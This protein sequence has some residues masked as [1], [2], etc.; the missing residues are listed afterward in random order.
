MLANYGVEGETYTLENGEPRF[1][2]MILNNDTYSYV[3][4]L[5]KYCLYEGPFE[6]DVGRYF[7]AF[8]E[9]QRE[10]VKRWEANRDEAW[11]LP[12]S[13]TLTSEESEARSALTMEIGT[14][15]SEMVLKFI[16]GDASIDAQWDEFISTIEN[17]GGQE[18]VDITQDALDRYNA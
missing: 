15:C 16:V 3:S 18:I 11:N 12:T 7:S 2:D 17:M 8:N 13:M 5:F 9:S 1:T 10:A 14:Y 4:A 6:L